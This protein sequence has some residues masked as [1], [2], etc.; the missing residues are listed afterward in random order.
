MTG[1]QVIHHLLLGAGAILAPKAPAAASPSPWNLIAGDFCA[2]GLDLQ[3]AIQAAK[4]EN[5]PPRPARQ[6]EFEE[7]ALAGR[8]H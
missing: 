5:G 7:I 2:V 6:L 8:T 4:K 1:R 3:Y